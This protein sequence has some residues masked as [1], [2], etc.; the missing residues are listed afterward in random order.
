MTSASKSNRLMLVV[1]AVIIIT[2]LIDVAFARL[3]DLIAKQPLSIWRF[4]VF[5]SIA[6]ICIVG[7]FFI[8]GY[9]NRKTTQVRTVAKLHIWR[10]HQIVRITQYVLIGIL[11][12]LVLQVFLE[13]QYLTLL[14]MIAVWV[15]Y[16]LAVGALGLLAW[17]FLAWSLSNRSFLIILYALS[18][19]SLSVNL[20]ITLV[21]V[22]D[23]LVDRPSLTKPFSAGSMV[24]IAPHS[25]TA[26]LN[27]GF[28][29]SSV[30]SFGL[31]WI[32]T[33]ALLH[34]RAQQLGKLR[35]WMIIGAPLVLFAS[36]FGSIFARV[37]DPLIATS[38]AVT[39]TI[40]ITMIFTLSKPIGG[41]LF[42]AAFFTIARNFKNDSVLRNYLII[43]AVGFVL[44][45]VCNQ[46]AVLAVTPFP[47]YGVVTT[48]FVGL[49]SYLILLGIFSSAISMSQDAKLR[50]M[51]RKTMLDQSGLLDTMG[52]AHLKQEIQKKVVEV[53]RDNSVKIIADTGIE[54]P[55]SEDDIKQYVDDV[56]KELRKKNGRRPDAR[57][58]D[59]WD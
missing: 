38:D 15:S 44:L 32:A 9:V 19:A 27:S 6:S 40:W 56:L 2:A 18:A 43:S 57:G 1:L 46:A 49:A 8:L 11:I 25:R 42:G 3:Y 59:S 53:M 51:V 23:I 52:S 50:V 58:S 10:I 24:S 14:V 55:P 22:T 28:F 26:M 34:H 45:F 36:Q 33:A 7:Q 35:H 29:V 21:Y 13:L 20:G 39:F 5:G 12:T 17:R 54:T 41:I 47:P 31:L 4:A 16:G 37:F 30:V 48:S